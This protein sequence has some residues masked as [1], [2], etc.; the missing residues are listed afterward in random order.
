MRVNRPSRLLVLTGILIAIL[1][2]YLGVLFNVQINQ[3]E[4]YLAKSLH[5]IAKEETIEAS[6]GVLTDRKGRLM[7]S[8]RSVYNLIFDSSLLKK[9]QDLNES[10]LRLL[11]LCSTQDRTWA[12]NLPIS[13]QAPYT[14]TLESLSDS[15]KLRFLKYLRTLDEGEE[16]LIAYALEHPELAEPSEEAAAEESS[17]REKGRDL[18]DRFPASAVTAELLADA[19]L[20]PYRV[21]M[22]MRAE[23]EIPTAFSPEEVRWVLGVRYELANRRLAGYPDCTLT[24]DVD[25]AFI[26][27]VTD[28]GYAGARISRSTVREYE[29]SYAS[30]ILG[31]VGALDPDDLENPFYKDYPRNA[32]VGKSGAEAAFETY[33]RGKNGRRV[34][35]TNSAGK[36][37][38]QYYS[39]EPE[40]GSTVELT[41]DLD[42]QQAVEDILAETVQQMN[43]K[44]GQ[45]ERGAAAVVEAVNTG[46]LLAVAN[47]P[48]YD[49]A[50]YRQDFA[51]LNA[52]PAKPLYNRATSQPY[53][54]GSTI[55]PLTAVASLEEGLVTP[56]QKLRSPW[57]WSYPGDPN[58]FTKCAGGDHGRIDVSQAITKSCNYFFA[59]MGYQMGMDTFQKYLQSFGLGEHTGIEIGD[60]PGRLPQ[61][62]VGEDQAPWAAY[63][64][65][66]QEY[67]PVQLANYIATLV[68][69]GQHREAHLLKAVKSYN[70]A[71]VLAVGNTEPVAEVSISDSTLKAVKLGM[72]NYTQPGGS[73]YAYFQNCVVSAGA[74]TGTAQLGQGITN[75]GVFVCFAPYEDP[76]IVVSMVIEKGGSGAALAASAV[77]ILNAYFAEDETGTAVTGENQLIP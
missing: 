72:Y 27:M 24:E 23:M 73:V 9:D 4:D 66:N 42:L 22:L 77:K 76:E 39:Q 6:R 52:D 51:E 36:I 28:G 25:T 58:S 12:D 49:L 43:D 21:L 29:T 68:S 63:G 34:V 33:L 54:P 1:L 67:T 45:T 3:H 61:N 10:I 40:P 47:Y 69:G 7:V 14:Y 15:Q 41:I 20:S 44:D 5:S 60:N 13:R 56:T 70:N 50:S 55:K 18:L 74:K 48:S 71:E 75:N 19:G 32:T 59:E 65:A 62:K 11:T 16:A 31:I 26:S 17:Q 46:E 8:N 37:T 38:G 35:S 57:I 30:H 64:Q 53:A 2:V